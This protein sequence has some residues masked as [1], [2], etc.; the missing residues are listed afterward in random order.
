M[1]LYYL[2]DYVEI[3]E[4]VL[5]FLECIVFLLEVKNY[6]MFFDRRYL[7]KGFRIKLRRLMGVILVIFVVGGI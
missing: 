6:Y 4:I 1:L 7:I 5:I 2:V 3:E